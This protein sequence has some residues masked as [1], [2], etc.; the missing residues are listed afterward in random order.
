MGRTIWWVLV[1]SLSI[2]EP[3]RCHFLRMCFGMRRL[4][5]MCMWLRWLTGCSCT[6]LLCV[7]VVRV[8]G[9]IH[10]GCGLPNVYQCG[11]IRGENIYTKICGMFMWWS[12]ASGRARLDELRPE[13][14]PALL[15]NMFGFVPCI[16]ADV[17]AVGFVFIHSLCLYVTCRE[18]WRD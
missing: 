14:Y 1:H 2:P 12:D 9:D 11:V 4:D 8:W 18:W 16:I 6:C 5:L 13:I 17:V 3:V 15:H 7:L 10:V